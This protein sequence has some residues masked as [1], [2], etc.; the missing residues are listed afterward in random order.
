VVGAASLAGYLG[1]EAALAPLTA[2]A[3]GEVVGSPSPDAVTIRWT[4]AG[5]GPRLDAIELAVAPP[6]TGTRIEVAY[7]PAAPE[8]L[9]VPGAELLAELE[10]AAGA[11]AFAAVGAALLLVSGAWQVLTR[12]RALRR[13]AGT[14]VPARRI[15]VQRG[16]TTRSWLE[17]DTG[18]WVPVHFVPALTTLPSPAPVRLHGDPARSAYVGVTLPSPEGAVHAPPSGRVRCSEPPGR[19]TD[20]PS[21]PDAQTVAAL[22]RYGWRRQLQ[23]DAGPLIL[24]PALGTVWALVIGTGFLGWLAATG[25]AATSALHIAALRGSDPS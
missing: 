4:P 2:R 7:D 9:V 14:A 6:A 15:R 8:R 20:N 12:G 1:A 19:Q 24:A 21:A 16:L 25:V 13:P 10:S 22:G 3:T 17:L 5:T 23:A 18:H 11:A